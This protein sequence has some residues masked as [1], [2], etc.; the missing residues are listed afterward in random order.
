[1]LS[2]TWYL[3]VL[4]ILAFAAFEVKLASAAGHGPNVSHAGRGSVVGCRAGSGTCHGNSGQFLRAENGIFG[5]PWSYG[6]V[7]WGGG[8]AGC[9]LGYGCGY[10]G[11]GDS[12]SVIGYQTERMPYFA[13]FPPV[14]YGYAENM[15]VL[16]TPIRLSWGGGVSNEPAPQSADSISPPPPPLR[17]VNP[18]YV[19]AK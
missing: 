7:S 18:Y 3:A 16:K 2:K 15:P 19:E 1:M 14:Y 6:S 10:T 17:I 11:W 12:P 5:Y 9:G 13:Q 4:A 8:I